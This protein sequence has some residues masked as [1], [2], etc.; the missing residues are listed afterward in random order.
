MNINIENNQL[1]I[2]IHLFTPIFTIE[3]SKITEFGIFV[4]DHD[5]LSISFKVEGAIQY[6]NCDNI[7]K[8]NFLNIVNFIEKKMDIPRKIYLD[9][10]DVTNNF[11]KVEDVYVLIRMD[12]LKYST[13]DKFDLILFGSM[14]IF[15]FVSHWLNPL[16]RTTIFTALFIIIFF[17]WLTDTRRFIKNIRN[18]FFTD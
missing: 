13:Q 9:D 6:I 14:V 18:W 8:D 3:V 4:K 12:K 16:I 1:Y 17:S 10:E 15:L 5:I 7:S 11:D 2:K